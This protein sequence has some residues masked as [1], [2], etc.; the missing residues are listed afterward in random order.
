VHAKSRQSRV[1]REERAVVRDSPDCAVQCGT[2]NLQTARR[3]YR[4]SC[5]C[6]LVMVVRIDSRVEEAELKGMKM[7]EATDANSKHDF[8]CSARRLTCLLGSFQNYLE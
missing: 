6:V 7:Q 8:L 2:V 4:W 5:R 1:R 3:S